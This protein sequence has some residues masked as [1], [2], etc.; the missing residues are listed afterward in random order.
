MRAV[1]HT[2]AIGDFILAVHED[3]AL[4]AQLVYHKAVVD[5]L[6]A[7]VNRR[8]EGLQRDAD[9]INRPHD[10]SAEPP[11]LQQ[12]QRLS[13]AIWHCQTPVLVIFSRRF[14]MQNLCLE[15]VRSGY[16][17]PLKAIV[18]NYRKVPFWST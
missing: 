17:N 16:M 13:L 11:R 12:K 10:T 14:S 2:L 6:L 5:D 8:A 9:N 3:R 1:D 18:I 15:P 7:H 4:P